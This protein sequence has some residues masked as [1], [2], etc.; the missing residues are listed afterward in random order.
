MHTCVIEWGSMNALDSFILECFRRLATEQ[1]MTNRT[2]G[3][4]G[5]EEMERGSDA[6]SRV[7]LNFLQPLKFDKDQI[8]EASK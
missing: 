4:E 2:E 6:K 1:G 3:G 5:V 8:T 7:Q